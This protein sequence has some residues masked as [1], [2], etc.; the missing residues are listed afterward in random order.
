MTPLRC[1]CTHLATVLNRASMIDN[2]ASSSFGCDV[3]CGCRPSPAGLA[4][5]PLYLPPGVL[6]TLLIGQSAEDLRQSEARK[7]VDEV[8]RD[9]RGRWQ[10]A[11]E[12]VRQLPRTCD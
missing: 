8:V 3:A 4:G 2:A 5:L 7:Q 12:H 6:A 9:H 11:D 1:M 10:G